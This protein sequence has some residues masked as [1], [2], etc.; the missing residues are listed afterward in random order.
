V[1]NGAA[2]PPAALLGLRELGGDV[3]EAWRDLAERALEPNAFFHPDMAV[4][5]ARHLSGGEHDRLLA[6]FG[7]GGALEFALPVRR[8]ARYRRVPVPAY[9]AWGHDQAFLD[10]PLV[11]PGDPVRA[12]TAAL[13]VLR[14]AGA[15]WLVFERLPGD[16][17]VRSALDAALPGGSSYARVLLQYERPVLRRRSEPTYVDGRLSSQR[18]KR[19]RRQGR[20]LEGELGGTLSLVDRA[21]TDVS[22][23]LE[24]F[25]E[26]ELAGWKGRA[27]TAL[28]S[29]PGEA[30]F[31]REAMTAF[32][33][34]G[35]AQ[36]W[37]LGTPERAAASLCA[38]VEDGGVFHTKTTFDERLAAHSPGLQLELALVDEFH[39]DPRLAWVDSCTSAGPS[40][41]ALLYPDRRPIHTVVVPLGGIRARASAHALQHGLRGRDWARERSRAMLRSARPG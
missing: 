21:E 33:R 22:G 16:G 28:A 9:R 37:E 41:S 19:L 5:A 8:A 4:A 34:R 20:N 39:R 2:V 36:L 38:I 18:R 40:P 10:T 35:R 6:V 1:R 27:G 31:F 32:A 7:D 24:R 17:P 14:S 23:A 13:G 29:Q 15:G 11:A 25:L 12:W 3:L 30:A 26:I